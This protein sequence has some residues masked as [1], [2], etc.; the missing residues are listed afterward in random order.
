MSKRI[1]LLVLVAAVSGLWAV[2]ARPQVEN[3]R[4]MDKDLKEFM[5]AKL[6][7]SKRVLEGLVLEDY[8]S[9]AENANQM[10]LLSLDASWRVL[11]T[12]QYVEHSSDFRRTTTKLTTAAKE[13]NLDG[14]TLAYVELTLKCVQ[15]HKYVRTVRTARL[16]EDG[17]RSGLAP[18][19][20]TAPAKRSPRAP[21]NSQ[22]QG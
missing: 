21:G 2:Q 19:A 4:P 10:Q 14:A 22:P 16:D 3:D 6:E 17:F 11:R 20:T 5:H 7:H 12:P 8:E 18:A 9:I 13:K 1:L 15:C